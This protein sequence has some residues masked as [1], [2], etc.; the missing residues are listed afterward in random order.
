MHYILGYCYVVKSLFIQVNN[1]RPRIVNTARSYRTPIKTVRPRVVNTARPNRTS[2]NAARANRFN[3][4]KSSTYWVWRPTKS[5]GASLS[6][7]RQNYIDAQGISKSV[8][9]WVPKE[10]KFLE[11]FVQGNPQHDDIGFVDSGWSRHMT[12]IKTHLGISKEA[13]TPRYLSPVVPLTKVSDEAVHKELGNKM[14][15]AA[16]TASS[17]EAEQD[18]VNAV[19]H[20]LMLPVQLPAAEVNRVRQLQA[21]VDKKRVIITESSIR[22]DLHLDDAE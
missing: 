7:K 19:R 6:F 22:R 18:S 20:M 12:G 4:V 3:A 10:I 17:L 13:R 5:N 21:L 2:V 11:S 1:V 8:M 9:A 14:E 16:T 15:R